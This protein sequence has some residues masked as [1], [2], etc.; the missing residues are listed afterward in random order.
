MSEEEK[1]GKYSQQQQ[2]FLDKF[3]QESFEGTDFTLAANIAKAAAGYSEDY[4]ID[5]II[6]TVKEELVSRCQGRLAMSAPRAI[7]ELTGI[8]TDPG[9]DNSKRILEITSTILDR[10]GIVKR[11]QMELE[12]KAVNGIL[13]LPPKNK[14]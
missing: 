1:L 13:L 4:S 2:A 11:E 14:E 9:K 3:I 7:K 8:L 10:V 6:E 5:R 12:V